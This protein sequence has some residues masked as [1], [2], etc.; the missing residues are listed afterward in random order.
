MNLQILPNWGKKLG[1]S[2]F[3][4]FGIDDFIRGWNSFDD[5]N[6]I[7]PY[8]NLLGVFTQ[9]LCVTL[10]MVGLLIYML[11]KEKIEDEYIKILRLESF[12]LTT[13]IAIITALVFFATSKGLELPLDYFIFN[14]M[15]VYFLIFRFKKY[16]NV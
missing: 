10:S 12:Q 2:L 14:Y 13:I 1:F 3:I 4:L 11:S 5:P 16:K 7:G 8:E 15:I 6:Y 9:T